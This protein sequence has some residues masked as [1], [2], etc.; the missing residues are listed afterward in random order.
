MWL[1]R[2]YAI[3][4]FSSVTTFVLVAMT[5][6]VYGWTVYS[7]EIWSQGY[8][9][10]QSLQRYERQLK[11]TNASL[12]NKMAEEAERPTTGL[13]SP[14]PGRTIFL[15]PASRNPN[16]TPPKTTPNSEIQQQTTSPLGY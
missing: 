13:L 12:T 2:F 8:R 5:L 11:T 1:L 7:Q 16:S 6:V 3:H 14:T 10:L 15:S 9:R 4:R